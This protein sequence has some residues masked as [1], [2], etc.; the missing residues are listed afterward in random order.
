M[1][2]NVNVKKQNDHEVMDDIIRHFVF[3]TD[4]QIELLWNNDTDCSMTE[5]KE[6]L[7]AYLSYVQRETTPNIVRYLTDFGCS[8]SDIEKFFVL[9]KELENNLEP[10]EKRLQRCREVILKYTL[11][12]TLCLLKNVLHDSE[13]DPHYS[14]VTADRLLKDYLIC[15][16]LEEEYSVREFLRTQ[17]YSAADI[18]L[19]YEKYRKECL[20]CYFREPKEPMYSNGI[21]KVYEVEGI[22]VIAILAEKENKIIDPRGV[23]FT[24]DRKVKWTKKLKLLNISDPNEL[25]GKSLE[26]LQ[27]ELGEAHVFLTFGEKENVPCYL[28][29][30]G[31]LIGF[32]G[33]CNSVTELIELDLLKP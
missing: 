19:F 2:K 31:Y 12:D 18:D 16:G 13:E 10:M 15:K 7:E 29:D 11:S 24:A 23:E 5:T 30:Q 25:L 17:G 6:R 21:L 1:M 3:E 14:A 4:S 9:S 33:P 32:S 22:F 26:E 27:K 8:S 28:T 20:H